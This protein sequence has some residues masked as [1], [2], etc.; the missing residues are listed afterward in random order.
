MSENISLP[1]VLVL[2]FD[3]VVIESNDIKTEAFRKTFERFPDYSDIMM[4]YHHT[5]VS[6]SRF[7]KFNHLLS[8]MGKADD[9]ALKSEIASFFSK[10]VFEAMMLVPLVEG[11]EHFLGN[12]SQKLPVYLASITPEEE[13]C[14]ILKERELSKWFKGVY[15]CPPWPKHLAINDILRIENCKPDDLLL[16]G[17]SA[18]DQ[19]AASLS[20]VK[21]IARNSGLDFIEPQ[22]T[23]F[24]DLTEIDTYF[25]N[26]LL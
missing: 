7:L 9:E 20:G 21:F 6:Q 14:L 22:P 13:L 24:K 16:I 15:G 19:K 23:Q 26:Y 1:K 17:D 10:S 18:G 5:N 3:G 11:A 4:D 12:I 25:K 2:D 8:L